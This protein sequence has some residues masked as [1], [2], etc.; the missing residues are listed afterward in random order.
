MSAAIGDSLGN[1]KTSEPRRSCDS[2]DAVTCL[3]ND[4]QTLD[5]SLASRPALESRWDE[6]TEQ[7]ED[8]AFD[9]GFRRRDSGECV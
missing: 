1:R 8:L 4:L 7:P 9:A 6:D 2:G 3:L 5:P